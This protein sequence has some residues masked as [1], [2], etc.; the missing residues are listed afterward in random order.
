MKK[1]F[2]LFLIIGWSLSCLAQENQT[3]NYKK[4]INFG[5]KGG[6]NTAMYFVD[7]FKIKDITINETQNN[8]KVGYFGGVFLR[9]NMKKHFIE[10]E[11]AYSVSKSEISF[12]KKGSQHPDIEPDYASINSTIHTIEL[13]VLYGYNFIK[14]GPYGM[15]FFFGPKFQYV[16]NKKS[17][18]EFTNFDQKGIEEKLYPF[19]INAVAGVGVNIS[20]IFFDF[21]YEV[22]LGNVSKSVTY[23]ESNTDGSENVANMVFKRK[24][25]LLSFSLGM[26]F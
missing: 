16:W 19:N 20:N 23:I 14:E 12:D 7:E 11:L 3:I 8:Y 18:L 13:P 6:F 22:G 4:K 21:R 26:I 2:L 17:K 1:V 9:I 10:P 24:S 15:A 5:I 25:N